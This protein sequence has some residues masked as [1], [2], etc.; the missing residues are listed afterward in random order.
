[1]PFFASPALPARRPVKLASIA[2][3]NVALWLG[4]AAAVWLALRP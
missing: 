2:L 3:L 1:M 4:V